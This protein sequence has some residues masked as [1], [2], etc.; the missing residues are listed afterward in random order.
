MNAPVLNTLQTVAREIKYLGVY[1]IEE[2]Q[3]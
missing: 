3:C 2:G 1:W